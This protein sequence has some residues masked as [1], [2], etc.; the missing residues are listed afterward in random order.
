VVSDGHGESVIF[1]HNDHLGSVSLLS[2]GQ[3]NLIADSVARYLPFGEWRTEPTTSDPSGSPL[4]DH[5]FTGQ[6]HNM[7]I[8]LYY[9]NARFY[10]PAVGR[11]ISA[12]VIVPDPT[13]PQ[14]FNRYTYVLNNSLRFTD[15]TGRYCYDP[16]AGAEL[17]GICVNEDGSTYSL[18]QSP[19][20]SYS[21][22]VP[23][24]IFSNEDLLYIVLAV[25]AE[26]SMG[27][28]SDQAQSM[29]AWTWFN[30]LSPG[31]AFDNIDR[32]NPAGCPSECA[33][34]A[35]IINDFLEEGLKYE[36]ATSEQRKAALNSA[37]TCYLTSGCS[38]W[39]TQFNNTLS[40]LTR[41]YASYSSGGRDPVD[42]STQFSHPSLLT[43][44]A[45]TF[46]DGWGLHQWLIGNFARYKTENPA[47]RYA[48]SDPFVFPY[49]EGGWGW[50]LIVTGNHGCVWD[51]SC[52]Q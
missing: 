13:N 46:T 34:W 24:K 19:S 42:G 5:G 33:A 48:I 45:I 47:F 23:R 38:R 27:R 28:H 30:R 32:S 12:D 22:P 29:Q 25:F 36:Q 16:S 31:K 3:G 7:D 43:R 4:T 20:R 49:P 51:S 6:K 10:A 8:G 15:P 17:M 50:A 37:Y 39:A 40:L 35:G 1:F 52:G 26:S 18:A 14:Q 2:D 9:Y 11:F 44:G 41:A 21:S